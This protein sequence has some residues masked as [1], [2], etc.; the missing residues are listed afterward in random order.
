MGTATVDE[1]KTACCDAI[2]LYPTKF[3]I[4][5]PCTS[6]DYNVDEGSCKL[7][8][9][10][11]YNGGIITESSFRDYYSKVSQTRLPPPPPELSPP[12]PSP[13]P[14]PPNP[15]PPQLPSPPDP[16]APP[17]PPPPPIAPYATQL[18]GT[19]MTDFTEQNCRTLA[20]TEGRMYVVQ[21]ITNAAYGCSWIPNSQNKLQVFNTLTTTAATC[22]SQNAMMQSVCICETQA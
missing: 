19:C 14:P 18:T 12:P 10:S 20:A 9:K 11:E 17:G 22:A 3:S 21:D 15:S 13:S 6:F 1:C 16:P 7:S 4:S 5:Q 8:W 2:T